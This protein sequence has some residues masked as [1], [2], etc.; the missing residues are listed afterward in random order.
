[1][2]FLPLIWAAVMRK[3]VRTILT[4]LSV[5]VAFTLFGITIGMNATF[6][7]V[8][9]GAHDDRIFSNQRF[10]GTGMPLAQAGQIAQLPGVGQVAYYSVLGGYHENERNRAFALMTSENYGKM[11]PDWP[12]TPAQWDMLH[13]TRDGVLVSRI[14]ATSRHLKPGDIFTIVSPQ[15]KRADG[16]AWD[17]KVVAITGDVPY[18]SA[19][20]MIGNYEYFNKALPLAKQD[21]IDQVNVRVSDPSQ[22]AAIAQRIDDHFA[23][24][25]TATQSITEK[26]ALDISSNGLDL[27]AL[28]RKI[29][30]AGMFMVL[31]LTAN[32][33]A[34]SVRE[35]LAEFA[36]LKTIGFTDRAVVLLVFLE[37][38][39]PCLLG[40]ALGVGLAAF[41]SGQLPRLFPPGQG[42]PPLPTM[43][44]MVF[45]WA[46]IAA[47]IVA[48]V[49]AALPALRLKRMD[50]A[51]ALS[52][53]AT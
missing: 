29:A 43:T 31:F 33:I 34:Q 22:T 12:I 8:A 42:T 51:T 14:Q 47:S 38:A 11:Y 24:S 41:L 7:K 27:A 26:A 3:P 5:M 36:T 52:G 25:A 35:R 30:L 45:V 4:L 6:D 32:G 20:F 10:F 16:K 21:K 44:A 13:K 17:M 46:A 2:R 48:L 23:N 50:I 39:L 1:M 37:A 15:N 28:D 19:G 18:M 49:S 40:A 53:R 9:A